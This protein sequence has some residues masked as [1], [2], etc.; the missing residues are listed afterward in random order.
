[1][2]AIG[3]EPNV[4]TSSDAPRSA[5]LWLAGIGGAAGS[6]SCNPGWRPGARLSRNLQSVEGELAQARLQGVLSPGRVLGVVVDEVACLKRSAYPSRR[7]SLLGRG[8]GRTAQGEGGVADRLCT[9][10]L[11]FCWPT[12][13]LAGANP[14]APSRNVSTLPAASTCRTYG[15]VCDRVTRSP[16]ANRE[17]PP[18]RGLALRWALRRET[19][20]RR[21]PRSSRLL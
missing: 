11:G 12:L 7:L 13:V 16:I 9:L 4:G 18:A 8:V 6:F 19:R 5:G 15:P 20:E 14:R 3:P 1:M 21:M 10:A 2:S 17:A